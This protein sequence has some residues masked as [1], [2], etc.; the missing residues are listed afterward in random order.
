VNFTSNSLEIW[1]EIDF[2]VFSA[3]FEMSKSLFEK[4]N[5]NKF[6][7]RKL[8]NLTKLSPFLQSGTSPLRPTQPSV[9]P[10]LPSL[11]SSAAAT[12]LSHLDGSILNAASSAGATATSS[13]ATRDSGIGKKI[14]N[15]AIE[16]QNKE[17]Q[18]R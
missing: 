13:E 5:K 17:G 8:Q 11:P 4:K 1:G 18:F 3:F 16:N 7:V 10:A 14:K 15:R 9:A 12:V 6:A 2:T